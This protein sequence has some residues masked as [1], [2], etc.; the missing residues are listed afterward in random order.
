MCLSKAY[1][2]KGGAKELLMTDIASV[3]VEDGKIVLKSL[4]G[5]KKEVAATIS[6]IDF[7]ASLLKLE[8]T[9]EGVP[10]D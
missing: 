9:S 6:E 5:E 1:I 4:F 8:L 10:V 3:K 7:T 2:E